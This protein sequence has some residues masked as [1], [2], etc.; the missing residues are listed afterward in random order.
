MPTIPHI[1]NY[2]L[3]DVSSFSTR[4][5]NSRKMRSTQLMGYGANNGHYYAPSCYHFGYSELEKYLNI[6]F[7]VLI[8]MV[9]EPNGS[10]IIHG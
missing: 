1:Q 3:H 7:T 9:T 4:R 5:G 2:S 10:N 8:L 6:R